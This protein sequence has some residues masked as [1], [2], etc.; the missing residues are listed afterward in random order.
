[1]YCRVNAQMREQDFN[2]VICCYDCPKQ[3]SCQDSCQNHPDKCKVK[4]AK[5]YITEV[6]NV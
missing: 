4:S 5:S 2:C 6:N 3:K 1:M